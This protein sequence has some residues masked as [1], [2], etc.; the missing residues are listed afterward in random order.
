MASCGTE[1]PTGH[2][3]A[4]GGRGVGAGGGGSGRLCGSAF[5]GGRRRLRGRGPLHAAPALCGG[6]A[7]RQASERPGPLRRSAA[8]PLG[9]ARPSAASRPR[10][11]RLQEEGSR[12]PGSLWS[13]SVLAS[14]AGS[15]G[16]R[17]APGS[18]LPPT[19]PPGPPARALPAPPCSS[20]VTRSPRPRPGW[21]GRGRAANCSPG[22]PRRALPRS[23]SCV[24][25]ALTA[26]SEGSRRRLGFV[27]LI[28]I[29]LLWGRFR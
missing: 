20:A 16:P 23:R 5:A 7:R 12:G 24:I 14:W 29:S 8:R 11:P 18:L 9:G 28:L 13:A 26:L 21:R 17:G 4:E 10:L 27:P 2:G 19:A 25:A 6:H 3:A 15:R 22:A 1:D